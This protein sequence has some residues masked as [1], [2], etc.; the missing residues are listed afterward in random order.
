MS[1]ILERLQV[2]LENT[3]RLRFFRGETYKQD[4]DDYLRELHLAL[5]VAANDID[6]LRARRSQ[7]EQAL[8]QAGDSIELQEAEQRGFERGRAFGVQYG[9]KSKVDE[10][11]ET[12][13]S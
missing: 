6:R 13:Q 9:G 1:D 4:A 7:L 8:S 2:L 11:H 10:K 3:K 5:V 12:N